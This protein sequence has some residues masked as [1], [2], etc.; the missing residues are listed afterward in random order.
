[1]KQMPSE[2]YNIAW[3]K[4]AEFVA[5]GEKERAL[6]LYRLLVHAFEDKALAFQLEG[7]LLL[8]FN[9]TIASERYAIAAQL[10]YKE[11]R[12]IEAAA[13]YEHL[14]TLEPE[15]AEYFLLIIQCY[16][17][18]SYTSRFIKH[19]IALSSLYLK[20]RK[21]ENIMM[22]VKQYEGV[23]QED[24]KHKI[25]QELIYLLGFTVAAHELVEH[26]LL[27]V[28]DYLAMQESKELHI[29]LTN[30]ENTQNP[31]FKKAKELLHE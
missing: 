24:E 21:I 17:T 4:L 16:K 29:F 6:A 25:Y 5:R 11:E 31:F 19:F 27:Q 28:I 1:M 9:D 18:L 22:L 30:L 26:M 13:V 10:Y 3:F 2:K 12:L 8:S 7:D 14:I 20:Q 23:C 15:N